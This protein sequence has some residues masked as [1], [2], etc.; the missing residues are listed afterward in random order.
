M[1]TI[2]EIRS[3]CISRLATLIDAR[4]ALHDALGYIEYA[5]QSVGQAW[6]EGLRSHKCEGFEALHYFAEA[7]ATK[8]T[9]DIMATT[10][11][12]AFLFARDVI[13]PLVENTD[14]PIVSLTG[15]TM[16]PALRNFDDVEAIWQADDN[17][18]VFQAFVEAFESKCNEM[19][20]QFIY[21]DFDNCI[22]AVGM[23]WYY[24]GPFEIH[25][26]SDFYNIANWK[27]KGYA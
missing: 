7:E 3:R 15:N 9:E 27:R 4:K 20:I 25:D 21:P 6:W 11:Q 10:H 19:N 2:D 12:T 14:D 22:M 18:D 23:N 8:L 13:L 5:S 26:D 17:G 16:S 24:S 1:R